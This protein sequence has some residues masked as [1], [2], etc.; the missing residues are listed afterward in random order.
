VFE[1]AND[2]TRAMFWFFT[3]YMR[4]RMQEAVVPFVPAGEKV[5][6]S[7]TPLQGIDIMFDPDTFM[8]KIPVK[9]A[10]KLLCYHYYESST[11]NFYASRRIS[12][13][14]L[15]LSFKIY[16]EAF[17][18]A[19]TYYN[20]TTG[21]ERSE[22]EFESYLEK[23]LS[24]GCRVASFGADHKL[25]PQMVMYR[26][27]IHPMISDYPKHITG[28]KMFRRTGKAE[29]ESTGV[30]M[31]FV[32]DV[33]IPVHRILGAYI[34]CYLT[35]PDADCPVYMLLALLESDFTGGKTGEYDW[36]NYEDKDYW[37][38]FLPEG[39][40]IDTR[41]NRLYFPIGLKADGE[42]MAAEESLRVGS[43]L[44]YVFP[45]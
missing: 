35:C 24:C 12:Y 28:K 21:Y 19:L 39:T 3:G 23:N 27:E 7:G 33:L 43:N 25:E 5:D 40:F 37:M 16:E 45:M 8:E 22:H 26:N 34:K 38:E 13:R 17:Q 30:R 10:G 15:R 36:D 2:V 6:L 9:F 20:D 41:L 32:T 42:L 18:N 29:R 4:A 11:T 31:E 44:D 1:E 14:C